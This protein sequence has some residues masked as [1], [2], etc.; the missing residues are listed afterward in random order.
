VERKILGRKGSHIEEEFYAII[1]WKALKESVNLLGHDSPATLLNT[2]LRG[3]DPDDYFSTVPYEKG[4]NLLYYLQ[5]VVGGPDVF[6]PYV[7]AHVQHF[8]NKSITTQEWKDFLYDYMAAHHGNDVVA[9][10]DRVDWHA[11]LKSPG[12]PPV[13]PHFDTTLAD[14]CFELAAR[15]DAARNSNKL[16]FAPS[17]I[18]QFNTLQKVVFLERLSDLTPL[19]HHLL[20]EMDRIYDFSAVRNSELR[21]R[22]Q[23]LC[24]Q[25]EYETIFPQ[26]VAFI[27][28]QGRMKYVRPL[29]RLLN[30]CKNGSALAKETYLKHKA[31]YHP[32]CAALIEKDIGLSN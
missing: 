1:G 2:D 11:W 6:E 15:W 16:D 25:A 20:S 31:F 14:K 9:A 7:K 17:D 28:E 4:F 32:I 26:V 24:L 23:H 29:Y 21:F 12:M 19:P 8:A 18:E 3:I 22:W 27:T 30:K 13:D 10:L 5:K